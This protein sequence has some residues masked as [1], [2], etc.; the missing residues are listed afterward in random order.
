MKVPRLLGID[1]ALSLVVCEDMDRGARALHVMMRPPL[2][3]ILGWGS[4]CHGCD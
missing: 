2:C 4:C 1:I 3:Y